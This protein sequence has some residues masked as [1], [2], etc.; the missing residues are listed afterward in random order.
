MCN[1]ENFNIVKLI[2]YKIKK[3]CLIENISINEF[4]LR[5]CLTQSTIQNIVQ[6]KTKN[7]KL[8]TILKICEGIGI[9]IEEFFSDSIFY[10]NDFIN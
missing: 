5:C 7:I 10:R 2:S 1:I 8:L 3:Y 4:S 6:V 9:S